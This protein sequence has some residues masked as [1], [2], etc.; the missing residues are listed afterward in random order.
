MEPVI[1]Y[2]A[3]KFPGQ[4]VNVTLVSP[5]YRFGLGCFFWDGQKERHDIMTLTALTKMFGKVK[6]A[7]AAYKSCERVEI[8]NCQIYS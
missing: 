6:D 8:P 5:N 4:D 3:K 1:D 2:V 7:V